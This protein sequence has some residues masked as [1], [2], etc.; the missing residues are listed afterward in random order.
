[1]K[2]AL[3][4]AAQKGLRP[5]SDAPEEIHD[6]M[7]HAFEI[8]DSLRRQ[9]KTATDNPLIYE[10]SITDSNSI[11]LISTDESL[12]S[13]FLPCRTPISQLVQ[14]NFLHQIRV[15]AGPSKIFELNYPFSNGNKPFNE[16]RVS[17]SSGFLLNNI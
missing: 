5:G 14:R 16:I 1:A 2:L 17:L 15:L 7:K 10:I 4:E 9:L 11:I 6:Y 12:P 3:T 8:S 13:R